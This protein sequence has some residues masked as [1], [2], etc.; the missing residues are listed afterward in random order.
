MGM[1][2]VG[3]AV[4]VDRLSLFCACLGGNSRTPLG[5]VSFV[6]NLIMALMGAVMIVRG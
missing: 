6:E 2:S 5:A 4:F 3:K 1:V